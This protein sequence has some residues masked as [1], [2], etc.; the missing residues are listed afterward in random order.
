MLDIFDP[1]TTASLLARIDKLTPT[2]QAQWGK[3]NVAQM[4]AH[5]CV[6]Y[7]QALGERTDAPPLLMRW[8]LRPLLRRVLVGPKPYRRNSPTAPA[9][10]ITDERDFARERDR[11]KDYIRRFQQLGAAH[12]D[13]RAQLS[14]GKLSSAEWSVLMYKHLD[15]HL[16]QFGV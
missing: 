16:Q 13:G 4:L 6:S 9:F 1:A 10:V 8:L 12:F 11:L 3:M 14:I 7:E 2:T 15:H 5:C